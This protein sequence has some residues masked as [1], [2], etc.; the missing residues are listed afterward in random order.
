MCHYIC[1]YMH[2]MLAFGEVDVSLEYFKC[3]S[4]IMVCT[5]FARVL[6]ESLL[7]VLLLLFVFVYIQF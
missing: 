6:F 2:L 3:I 7:I 1:L 4:R 5:R